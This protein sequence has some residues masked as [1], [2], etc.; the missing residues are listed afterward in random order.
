MAKKS[1]KPEKTM[2]E[3]LFFEL[4]LE[5]GL[6]VSTIR[7]VINNGQSRFT[8]HVISNNEFN[9]V[10]WPYFGVFRAKHKSVQVL[11]YM[12]GLDE[13]QKKFFRDQ[14]RRKKWENYQKAKKNGKNKA[15]GG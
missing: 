13:I 7:D 8:A 10:R 9:G 2:N 5:M 6:P 4:S 15:S 14:L 11:S 12:K 3:S 1:T